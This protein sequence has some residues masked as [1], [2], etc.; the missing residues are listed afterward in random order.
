MCYNIGVPDR[1]RQRKEKPQNIERPQDM[2]T[3]K[4][5]HIF[6]AALLENLNKCTIEV[7]DY[8]SMRCG[9][10]SMLIGLPE[11]SEAD[12]DERAFRAYQICE[13]IID[14]AQPREYED[15]D[16]V[17]ASW[18]RAFC[19]V[20]C[21]EARLDIDVDDDEK[22]FT[23]DAEN[24]GDEIADKLAALIEEHLGIKLVDGGC[25]YSLSWYQFPYHFEA[26]EK[27][28]VTPPDYHGAC[29]F[30]AA[31]EKAMN[32][33]IDACT[34]FEVEEIA[35]DNK[36]NLLAGA[37]NE[38]QTY[39]RVTEIC[40]IIIK[41]ANPKTFAEAQN[42]V[43]KWQGV[44]TALTGDDTLELA[45]FDDEDGDADFEDADYI[46]LVCGDNYGCY[47][48]I[49]RQLA[50]LICEKLNVEILHTEK[51]TCFEWVDMSKPQ[52]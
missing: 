8:I 45:A 4:A 36:H 30:D 33:I 16:A 7:I 38:K 2:N 48:F 40:E 32:E 41:K 29:D 23:F 51:Q 14:K 43:E 31:M 28:V 44:Y 5:N 50:K 42:V 24:V 13:I 11:G 3:T 35:L 10:E 20:G 6:S 17:L 34:A 9:A 19:A 25:E 15:L 47:H 49:G 1:G 18:Y 27:N 37:K 21:D 39:D 46:Q 26:K 52:A 12:F 22:T